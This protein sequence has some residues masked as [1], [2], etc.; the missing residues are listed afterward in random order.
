MAVEMGAL[1]HHL[2]C[3]PIVVTGL[4]SFLLAPYRWDHEHAN[5]G[6]RYKH[7]VR[8]SSVRCAVIVMQKKKVLTIFD[9]GPEVL[10][11]LDLGPKVLT[12]FDW[13]QKC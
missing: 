8:N 5:S 10:T 12:I 1:G 3:C 7:I 6:W 2:P 13:G 11:I 4:F 9:L